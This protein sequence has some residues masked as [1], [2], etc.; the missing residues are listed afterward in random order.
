VLVIHGIGRQ[1][2]LATVATASQAWLRSLRAAGAPTEAHGVLLRLA[3]RDHSA[4]RLRAAAAEGAPEASAVRTNDASV[5]GYAEVDIVEFAWQHLVQGG[6]RAPHVLA[7][8]V[9]TGLAPLDLRRHWRVLR[10]AGQAPPAAAAVVAR[11]SGL[12]VAL[13]AAVITLLVLLLGAAAA[14]PRAWPQLVTLST[15]LSLGLGFG[16]LVTLAVGATGVGLSVALLVSAV[17]DLSASSALRRDHARDGLAWAGSYGGEVRGWAR[18]ALVVAAL[19][20]LIGAATL[21]LSWSSWPPVLAVITAVLYAPGVAQAAA[22]ALLLWWLGRVLV[23]YVGD[24]ALYV[25]SDT[26]SPFQ[27]SRA[28]IKREGAALLEAL[29]RGGET[30]DDVAGAPRYD[31]V[32]VVGHSL[33]S[34]IAYDLLNTLSRA[35][36]AEGGA[37]SEPILKLRGLLTFGS[38]LDKVAYFFRE[39]VSDDASVHAQLLSQR[40]ATKRRPSRRDDGPY[41]LAPYDVPLAWLHWLHLHAVADPISDPLAFYDVDEVR[42]CPYRWPWGAHGRYWRD[43]ATYAALDELLRRS[44]ARLRP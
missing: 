24:I 20:A 10:E 23:H 11:Q 8:L 44:A 21:A 22:S 1:P 9:A 14:L 12:A 30:A 41:R 13:V 32:V 40:H 28:A 38:P 43:P 18:A 35:A 4:V 5:A 33:G 39:R 16:A 3:G 27:R 29:L 15:E 17:R 19:S 2:P 42:H 36:R 31:A 34:V 37:G 26:S 6:I 25:T 7:W